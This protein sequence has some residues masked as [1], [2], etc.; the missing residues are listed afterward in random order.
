M[1]K[2]KFSKLIMMTL[3]I[4]MVLALITPSFTSNAKEPTNAVCFV[5]VGESLVTGTPYANNFVSLTN[6]DSSVAK[7]TFNGTTGE[8]T[9]NAYKAGKTNITLR[10]GTKTDYIDYVYTVNAIDLFNHVTFTYSYNNITVNYDSSNL[11]SDCTPVFSQDGSTWTITAKF[12]RPL[13]NETPVIYKAYR[14]N[15]VVTGSI[16]ALQYEK[17]EK[18]TTS[19]ID[20]NLELSVGDTYDIGKD[21]TE[22]YRYYLING[23]NN[24]TFDENKLVLTAND[25]GNTTLTVNTQTDPYFASDGTRTVTTVEHT[26]KIKIKDGKDSSGGSGT[27]PAPTDPSGSDDKGSDSGSNTIPSPNEATKPTNTPG[28]WKSD[29]RGW[30]YE[31]T[32]GSYPQWDWLYIDGFW[33]FFD[34]NGYMDYNAYR[35]GCWIRPDGTW[36]YDYCDGTWKSDGTGWWYEDNG[37]YPTDQWLKIDGYWYY[38]KAD[39]YM[40]AKQWVGN[41][42]LTS[43]GSM[44]T[45]CYIG[46]Y[47]VGADGAWVQ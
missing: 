33:Y 29:A 11:P 47:W 10:L 18:N 12:K 6:G 22:R 37:W 32:D 34:R 40:A 17:K 35:F 26:Y 3:I 31:L 25:T 21:L 19:N 24:I 30:W 42:Y 23:R 20:H 43:N 1:K 5:D 16:K 13:E 39:G 38:F 8:L 15:G 4:C 7:G 27:N 36:D 9:I 45:N 41:Y 44:A 14:V 46:S 28:T 2:K